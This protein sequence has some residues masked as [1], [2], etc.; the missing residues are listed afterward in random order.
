MILP[1]RTL[2]I[3]FLFLF[4]SSTI[5]AKTLYYKKEIDHLLQYVKQTKCLYI[6]N[7]DA[8]DGIAAVEHIQRKYD[9]YKNEIH[10][11]EDFIRL[12]ATKSTMSGIRYYI[13]CKNSE[14]VESNIWLLEELKR[15]RKK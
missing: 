7:G 11:T 12:S 5:S 4:F 3:I 13:Q 10:T 2:S 8:H 14:K 1:M 9:Y 6:R 15:F